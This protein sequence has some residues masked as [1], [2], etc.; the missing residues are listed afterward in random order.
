MTDGIRAVLAEDEV[1]LGGATAIGAADEMNIASRERA[2][3]ETRRD[4]FE[5]RGVLR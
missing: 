2:V 3:R 1:V 4:L 5:D